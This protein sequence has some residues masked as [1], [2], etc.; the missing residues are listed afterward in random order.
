MTLC[1]SRELRDGGMGERWSV[2]DRKDGKD[3]WADFRL[4]VGSFPSL[5]SLSS[6]SLNAQPLLS[7][8]FKQEPTG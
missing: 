8:Q 3:K 7:D 2:K 4:N 1:R 6:L 5:R